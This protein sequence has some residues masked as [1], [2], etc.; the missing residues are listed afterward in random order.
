MSGVLIAF[1][2]GRRSCRGAPSLSGLD[3]SANPSRGARHP[4]ASSLAHE[5]NRDGRGPTEAHAKDLE[6]DEV[7]NR[8]DEPGTLE[9]AAVHA[10]RSRVPRPALRLA[11]TAG[12]RERR[13]AAATTRRQRFAPLPSKSFS[14][15]RPIVTTGQLTRN[16]CH[17]THPGSHAPAEIL[18]RTRAEEPATK[19]GRLR[20]RPP[21]LQ[22]RR[23]I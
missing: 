22:D 4:L 14:P 2:A 13:R 10:P 6:T 15:F 12:R 7:G 5:V 18:A 1:L 9:L 19:P 16:E 17:C 3:V 8:L 21:L 20:F 11:R 23:K